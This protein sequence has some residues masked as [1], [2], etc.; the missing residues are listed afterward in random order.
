M[1]GTCDRMR[2]GAFY[3]EMAKIRQMAIEE[4]YRSR[5]IGTELV[6]RA[7]T[8]VRARNISHG[9]AACPCIG[10]PIF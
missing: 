4:S 3:E 8:A 6:K 7:E 5:G 2:V 9:N 1:I 10:A